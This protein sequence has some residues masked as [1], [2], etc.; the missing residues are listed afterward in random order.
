MDENYYV[1]LGKLKEGVEV[2]IA[3]DAEDGE[4]SDIVEFVV[5][6]GNGAQGVELGVVE[7]KNDRELA[8]VVDEK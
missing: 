3:L 1:K 5:S 8:V 7:E 2:R 4:E 6:L